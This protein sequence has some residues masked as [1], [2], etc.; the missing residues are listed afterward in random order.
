IEI[1][2]PPKP[3]D[4]NN[5]STKAARHGVQIHIVGAARA[6]D[7]ILG[8]D[9]EGG[10]VR[11]AGNGPGR[12]HWYEG[13]RADFFE[14]LLGE[15]KV[16]SRLNPKKRHW[17]PRTDRRNEALDCT[18]YAL[19]LSRHLRLHLRRAAQWDVIEMSLRQGVL[20]PADE[21]PAGIV[22]TPAQPSASRQPEPIAA[23]QDADDVDVIDDERSPELD[24][25]A[26]AAQAAFTQLLA[27]RKAR[28]GQRR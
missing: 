27:Q 2:T 7:T 10:R 16:P 12:M 17:K 22:Q 21:I 19:Y 5:R 11:L 1:W 6:K 25:R 24:V 28:N 14:Q 4:P 8:W 26:A 18:V 23:Q 9:Q 20:L 3:I 13:V 15:L